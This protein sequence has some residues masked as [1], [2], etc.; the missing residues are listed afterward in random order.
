MGRPHDVAEAAFFLASADA[1][2]I[3]GSILYVDGGWTSFGNAGNASEIADEA[4]DLRG[5]AE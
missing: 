1:S 5:T 4:P 3:N 2:Y